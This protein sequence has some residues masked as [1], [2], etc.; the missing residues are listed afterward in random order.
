[1][2]KLAALFLR[3]CDLLEAEGR[4]LKQNVQIVGL[5]CGLSAL[6][7]AAAGAALVFLVIAIYKALSDILSPVIVL[8][9]LA[10][11]CA[12]MAGVTFWSAKKCV[13]KGSG[14]K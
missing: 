3:F 2:K 14:S 7:F 1:M 5:G 4:L 8:L 11:V 6:G 10:L 13:Q 9:I 12:I